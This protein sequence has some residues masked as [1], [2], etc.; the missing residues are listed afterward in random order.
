MP[1]AT[2]YEALALKIVPKGRERSRSDLRELIAKNIAAEVDKALTRQRA[3]QFP[4]LSDLESTLRKRSVELD[5]HEADLVKREG[6]I[7]ASVE[8]QLKKR[9]AELD[10]IELAAKEAAARGA[11]LESRLAA[12][13]A[14]VDAWDQYCKGLGEID[15]N[16]KRF[17]TLRTVCASFIKKEKK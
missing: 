1:T 9:I 4:E 10:R 6:A 3:E 5:K 2:D 14:A 17:D 8:A 15:E 16:G 13:V 11:A 12:V 7:K